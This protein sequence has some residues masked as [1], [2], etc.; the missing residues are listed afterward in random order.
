MVRFNFQTDYTP[1]IQAGTELLISHIVCL[2]IV[3]VIINIKTECANI[4]SFIEESMP[5]VGQ[6]FSLM[7]F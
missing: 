6:A 3:F 7:F 5:I 1:S 2:L 4:R